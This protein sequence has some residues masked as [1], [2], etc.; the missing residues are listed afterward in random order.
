M[1]TFQAAI[2]QLANQRMPLVIA[3][4]QAEAASSSLGQPDVWGG[5][6]GVGNGMLFLWQGNFLQLKSWLDRSMRWGPNCFRISMYM[7]ANGGPQY[8]V[9]KTQYAILSNCR[10]TEAVAAIACPADMLQPICN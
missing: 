4:S 9:C 10:M 6:A 1:C 8:T 5:G 7:C 3:C 2:E